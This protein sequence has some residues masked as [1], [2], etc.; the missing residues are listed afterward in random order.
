[1]LRWTRTQAF[2]G[3]GRVATALFV[4]TMAAGICQTAFALWEIAQ[5][6]SPIADP[7]WPKGA[8]AVF[9]NPDRISYGRHGF[10][11]LYMAN[12]RG[13]AKALNA[14]LADYAKVDAKT[15][16]LVVHDGVQ[17]GFWEEGADWAFTV[18]APADRRPFPGDIKSSL[19]R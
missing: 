1:M 4:L 3:I 14:I 18:W 12:F 9:N 6:N 17:H 10:G 19:R 15:K 11:G 13:D 5:G 16:R 2:R 7:G 8:A